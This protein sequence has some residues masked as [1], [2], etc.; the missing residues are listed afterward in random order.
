MEFGGQQGMPFGSGTPGW[1]Y[2]AWINGIGAVLT[3]AATVIELV[4]KF[5][6]GAWL[7]AI[8]IPLLVLMFLA[9]HRAYVRIGAELGI[10]QVPP[11]RVD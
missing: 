5:L 1:V 2:R 9:V 8:I 6:A 11:P 10:G 7:V 3:F 4:S